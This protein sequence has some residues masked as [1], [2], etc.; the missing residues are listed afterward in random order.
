MGLNLTLEQDDIIMM[1]GG[2]VI[3]IE[4]VNSKPMEVLITIS[5]PHAGGVSL[6]H[7][8]ME[9]GDSMKVGR[10]MILASTI[11]RQTKGNLCVRITVDAP[12]DVK[13]HRFHTHQSDEWLEKII[14]KFDESDDIA[15][16]QLGL[17]VLLFEEE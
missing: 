4:E 16:I 17:E 13:V 9:I 6:E 14:N 5:K 15:S 11:N 2:I 1:S 7:K 3:V 10:A 12:K 8:T